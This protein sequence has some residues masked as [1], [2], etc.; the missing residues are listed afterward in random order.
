MKHSFVWLVVVVGGGGGG[1][2]GGLYS[3]H[4]AVVG[5]GEGPGS[6]GSFL[7]FWSN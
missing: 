3:S 6:P 7:T 1:G 4:S 2:G 5:P